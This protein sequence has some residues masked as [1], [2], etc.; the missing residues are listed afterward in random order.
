MIQ[1]DQE[2]AVTRERIEYFLDLLARLRVSSCPEELA[3]VSSGYRAEIER[4]HRRGSG[5]SDAAGGAGEGRL[6]ESG[7]DAD[8]PL[9]KLNQEASPSFCS[10]FCSGGH[11]GAFLGR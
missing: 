8:F 2:L 3:L 11:R 5:L 6:S 4:M 9:G 10:G 7:A 1:N